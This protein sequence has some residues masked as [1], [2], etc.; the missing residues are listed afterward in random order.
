[1]S[2][3]TGDWHLLGVDSDPVPASE[4]DVDDVAADYET[5]GQDLDE[6]HS[7]LSK[8]SRLE[9]WRGDAAEAFAETADD[10]LG[11]LRKAADKYIAAGKALRTY[12]GHVGT[13]RTDSWQALQ[14]A[15]D[16]D[17]RRQNNEGD[18]LQ[19]VDDPTPQQV[20][21][22]QNQSTRLTNANSDLTAARTKLQNALSTL[23]NHA[24]D[25]AKAIKNASESFKD[26][27]FKDDILRHN[28]EILK[29]VVKVL[30][31]AAVVIAVAALALALVASAPFALIV[32]GI[33]AAVALVITRSLL[34]LSDTGSATWADVG[35]DVVGLAFACVGGKAAVSLARSSGALA[36]TFSGLRTAATAAARSNLP[37]YTRFALRFSGSNNPLTRPFGNWAARQ[38]DDAARPALSQIDAIANL[39]PTW[40]QT[41][42]RLDRDMATISGQLGKLGKL[43]LPGVNVAQI[44]SQLDDLSAAL[45]KALKWNFV[46]TGFSADGAWDVAGTSPAEAVRGEL[47]EEL[48]QLHWRIT[49]AGR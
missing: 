27:W 36:T 49:V 23:E 6:A 19:G 18:P 13:A 45:P 4:M 26:H 48:S 5:R 39:K 37:F 14:D 24:E 28:L 43:D 38:L 9:G 25:C 2:K 16:A 11:D 10:V 33:V 17:K 40:Q 3:R 42:F 30:E 8:L 22:A 41:L 44:T 34:V 35:W 21:A 20:T 46:N 47:A 12:A 29:I 1:V 15:E 32:A 7:L 31:I